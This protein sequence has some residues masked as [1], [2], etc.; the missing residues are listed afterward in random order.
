MGIY[1]FCGFH[2]SPFLMLGQDGSK[3]RQTTG[4]S[5]GKPVLVA[6]LTR[7]FYGSKWVDRM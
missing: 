4:L 7:Q 2:E 6:G 3:T 1:T 5:W